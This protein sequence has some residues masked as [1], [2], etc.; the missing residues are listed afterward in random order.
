MYLAVA[1]M[2]AV[3]RMGED[4]SCRVA[5]TGFVLVLVIVV[6]KHGRNSGWMKNYTLPEPSLAPAEA[7]A[8]WVVKGFG[9]LYLLSTAWPARWTRPPATSRT[10]ATLAATLRASTAMREVLTWS[11]ASCQKSQSLEGLFV[12]V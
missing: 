2:A 12:C 9:S 3:K 10:R 5:C 11:K 7:R 8:I 1:E 4:G 6:V